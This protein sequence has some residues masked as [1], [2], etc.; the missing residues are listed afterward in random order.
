MTG[1]SDQALERAVLG[2][3]PSI[4][5]RNDEWYW[6]RTEPMQSESTKKHR[7]VPNYLKTM[8]GS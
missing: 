8:Q 5:S 1:K 3:A 7:Q 2:F 4:W 6:I